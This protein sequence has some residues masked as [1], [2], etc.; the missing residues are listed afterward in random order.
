M[1]TFFCSYN[2]KQ[3]F[4][5][6]RNAV[7]NHDSGKCH[8]VWSKFH[9]P[10]K[11]FGW[12]VYAGHNNAATV[13]LRPL[14]LDVKWVSRCIFLKAVLKDFPITHRAASDKPGE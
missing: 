5:H 2:L 11:F 1:K 14:A 12:Y 8:K 9:R 6:I 13:F 4:C 7:E 10:P 3:R